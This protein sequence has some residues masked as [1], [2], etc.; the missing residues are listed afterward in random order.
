MLKREMKNKHVDKMTSYQDFADGP[1]VKNLP[2]KSGGHGFDP[3][4]GR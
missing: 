4:S 3:W 2:S 1:V